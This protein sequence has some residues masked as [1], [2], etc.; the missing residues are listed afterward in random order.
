MEFWRK[1]L[2]IMDADMTT[3]TMYGWFHILFFALSIAV[4]IL[5][6]F[7]YK[8][9][10]IT[11][12]RR[13]VLVVAI[14]V[15]VIEI[16]KQIN[17]SFS[18]SDGIAFDYQWYIFPWQFCST[19]MY[20]GLLAG[21]TKG[22]FHDYMCCFLSTFAVFAGAA[23]MFYPGDVFIGTIGINIQTMI[24]HGSMI[25]VGIF[26]F[27]TNHVKAEWKTLFKAIPVFAGCV[28]VAVILNEVGHAVGLTE[29][30]F[31]NMFYI[32]RHED[33]HLP[34]YSLVQEV[35]PYPWSLILYLIGFTAAAG[36]MLLLA[37]GI[38]KLAAVIGRKSSTK[39]ID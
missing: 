10:Y 38:K 32:S 15:I 18:Y 31:F 12:V 7:L 19:P 35:V 22:K 5:L 24:C 8:K 9:G 39:V 14:T 2:E 28:T 30:H 3:P 26:L 23:V 6:C 16:Y 4:A 34:V 25:T 27:Y 1:V 13:V 20:I 36:I 11:N 37:M 33:G 17:Y 21:L 29:D